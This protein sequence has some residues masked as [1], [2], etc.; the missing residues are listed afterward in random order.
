[1][2]ILIA[3]A[4]GAIGIPLIKKLVLNNI[5]VFALTRSIK[6]KEIIAKLGATPMVVDIFDENNVKQAL[7]NCQ[8]DVIVD[9]LT[10]LPKNY[11]PF[12]MQKAAANDK[13]IRIEGGL[14]LLK[15]AE[16][17]SVTTYIQ[18]SCA[19]WYEP[20]SHL[21]TEEDLFAF[22]AT[23]GIVAG[24]KVYQEIEQRLLHS[25]ILK[26]IILRF[27]FFYG[28]NTWYAKDGSIADQVKKQAYPIIGKG[29]GMWN[30]VHVEDAA[31]AI[32]LALNA[33][34]IIY[35]IVSDSPITQADFLNH[36]AN[37]LAAP[38]PLRRTIEE[39]TKINGPD[40]VYYATQL[41]GASNK[42]A[43]NELS[44]SPRPLEW[45]KVK[46]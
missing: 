5:E 23:P 13:K 24:I 46:S 33:P 3:G 20:G 21:A 2:K 34:S 11:T 16:D 22:N 30:F 18:Q 6:K 41:R 19:F 36:Y 39:E 25:S 42:K 38:E 40:S 35:N 10:S 7:A 8:P 32:Y 1:M 31:N 9:M 12:E 45:L 17:L 29:D 37:W 28:P 44:F 43:K 15:A 14:N 27:G 4:T 26:K